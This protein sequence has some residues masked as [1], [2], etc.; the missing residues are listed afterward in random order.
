MTEPMIGD[1]YTT[2]TSKVEG[3]VVEKVPNKTGSIRLRLITT[4][5]TTRWTTWVPEK[6]G[7]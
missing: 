4:E 7:A 3:F 2:K 5:L 6:V 1:L